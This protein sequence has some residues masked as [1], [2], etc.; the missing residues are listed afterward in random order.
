MP[1]RPGVRGQG[2]EVT[3]PAGQPPHD[4]Q[5]RA[6]G[7]RSDS[8]GRTVDSRAGTVEK[9]RIGEMKMAGQ[10]NGDHEL[11]EELDEEK[12]WQ[13]EQFIGVSFIR[14]RS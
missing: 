8:D 9:K 1:V 4:W 2:S 11:E 3:G 6:L 10:G 13:V 5:L 14:G 7:G 12:A